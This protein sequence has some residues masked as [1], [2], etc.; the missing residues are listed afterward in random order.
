VWLDPGF[1]EHVLVVWP[2][3]AAQCC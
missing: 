3:N 1:G 2:I